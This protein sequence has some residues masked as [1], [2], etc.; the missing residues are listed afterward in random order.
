MNNEEIIRRLYEAFA[1]GDVPAVLARFSDNI[2]WHE[3]EGTPYGGVYEGG[4]AIVE[5]VFMKLATEWTGYTVSPEEFY[6]AGSTVVVLGRYSGRFNATGKEM[7]VPFAHVWT[8]D[9][10]E[11]TR[12]IQFT[13]T[14][15]MARA[16]EA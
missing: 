14:V 9:N 10:G 3:A 13:D 5:N 1:Q 4:N 2:V 12:F 7:S 8:L 16:L 15:V 11:V 6:D